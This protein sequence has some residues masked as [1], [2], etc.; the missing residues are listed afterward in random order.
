MN[1]PSIAK[2]AKIKGIHVM[3]TGDFTHPEWLKELKSSLRPI[4][5]GTFE[6]AGIKFFLTSEVSNIFYRHGKC[7][8][9][10]NIILAPDFETVEKIIRQISGYGKLAS[11][12][13]PILGLD[14]EK[15]VAMVLEASADCVIIPGH[16]WTPHFG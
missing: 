12:G 11:D 16:A 8:K 2:W 15:M 6:H 9:V 10:H 13:R 1:I 5:P 7:Y 3:G 14:P 4:G